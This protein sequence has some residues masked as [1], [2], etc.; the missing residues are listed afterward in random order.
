M[1]LSGLG[2]VFKP[3][4]KAAS[5]RRLAS[6][7][8]YFSEFIGAI[9]A[10]TKIPHSAMR[11]GTF[12]IALKL[13][14]HINE[15]IGKVVAAHGVLENRVQELLFDL[16]KVGYPQGRVAFE[17]R[18]PAQMFGIIRRLL[19]LWGIQVD[20]NLEDFESE[21]RRRSR[22]R[23]KLAHGVWVKLPSGDLGLR[24]TEGQIKTDA[25]IHD[26][27]YLPEVQEVPEDYFKN[28]RTEIM[29]TAIKVGDLQKVVKRALQALT[30]KSPQQ[31]D[32]SSHTEDRSGQE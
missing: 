30:E 17:Y 13:P 22:E 27:A 16:M 21:I 7:F 25:G 1:L 4:R 6:S 29:A 18:H 26:R 19:D 3:P 10:K 20:A 32:K 5:N 9:M 23:D 12:P 11:G 15:G 14:S 28:T 31:S 2:G 24:V 8:E